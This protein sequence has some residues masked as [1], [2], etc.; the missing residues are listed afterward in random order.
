[1]TSDGISKRDW[2]RVTEVAIRIVNVS[3]LRNDELVLPYTRQMLCLL[4]RLQRKYGELPSL[5]ATRADYTEDESERLRLLKRAYRLA[6]TRHDKV[7]CVLIASSIAEIYIEDL[8]NVEKG[9][10]WLDSLESCLSEY[11]DESEMREFRR[12]KKKFTML[13]SNAAT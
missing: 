5:L 3:S 4:D 8:R 1:M 6:K 11:R 9:K 7:N 13:S 2:D 12:L 10:S